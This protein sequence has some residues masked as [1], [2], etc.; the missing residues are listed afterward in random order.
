MSRLSDEEVK[1]YRKDSRKGKAAADLLANPLLAD[2][3]KR[4]LDEAVDA[5]QNTIP[6]A[7]EDREDL[8]CYYRAAKRFEADLMMLIET[9]QYADSMLAH[10]HGEER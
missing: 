6:S 3:L 4:V 10:I 9:G 5:W 8:Y 1:L 2:T 7:V